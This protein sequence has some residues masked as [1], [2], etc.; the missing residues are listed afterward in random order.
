MS[1]ETCPY[2]NWST[3]H[4]EFFY[5]THDPTTVDRQGGD[6]GTREDEA[7]SLFMV[8]WSLH[9]IPFGDFYPFP[10]AESYCQASDWRSPS[11]VFHTER[12]ED[13]NRDIRGE[14]MVGCGGLPPAVPFQ[15]SGGLSVPY[16]SLALVGYQW[17]MAWA[18]MF[19]WLFSQAHWHTCV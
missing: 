16:T 8:D 3:F 15:E 18:K 7:T 1:S 2:T 9:R 17:D 14:A 11:Q 4:P 12:K 10:W 5:R 6:V 13:R 19:L